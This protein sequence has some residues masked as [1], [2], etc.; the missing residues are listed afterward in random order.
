MNGSTWNINS[1][2]YVGYSGVGTLNLTNGGSVLAAGNTYVGINKG[3]AGVINFGTNGGILSTQ[4]LFAAPSQLTGIGTIYTGGL[5]SDVNLVFDQNYDP[6]APVP[7][8]GSIA[9]YLSGG[10]DLGAGWNGTGYLTI[11]DGLY[12]SSANGFLGYHSGST[13]VAT[14]SAMGFDIRST[15]DNRGDLYVGYSGSGTLNIYSGSGTQ[16]IGAA[17]SVFVGGNGYIGYN[18]GSTGVVTVGGT[19]SNW[20]IYGDLYV[21]NSGSG[22]LNIDGGSVWVAGDTYVGINTSS[23]DMISLNGGTFS[24][25]TIFA[26]QSQLTGTG[27]INA[28]GLV[29]DDIGLIFDSTHGLTQTFTLNG[30]SITLNLD[31]SNPGIWGNGSIGTPSLLIRD[32]MAVP[33]GPGY[34]G[35]YSGS[36]CEATVTG[37][38]SNWGTNGSLYIGYAANGT[39]NAVN[40]GSVGSCELYVGYSASGTLNITN[41]SSVFDCFFHSSRSSAGYIGYNSGSSGTA[42]VSGAGS[43]WTNSGALYV[44]YAGSGTLLDHQRRQRHQLL[45]QLY[46]YSDGYIGYYPSSTG[47]VTVDGSGSTWTNTAAVLLRRLLRQRD[48]EHHQRR[49]RHDRHFYRTAT[50]ATIPARRAR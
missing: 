47:T 8:F 21:G 12:V 6:N 20:I 5:V 9:V 1:D 22:R 26:T 25:R 28:R 49:K 18:S 17:A 34:I 31:L 27:T 37:S 50:S 23:T 41:G 2:L 24:T 15:W 42:T 32:G 39:L 48:A 29:N 33:S 4:S 45:Q 43:T 7:G 16:N 36:P 46:C 38:N 3:S 11:Q 35:Y 44:G 10:G 19:A 14:V 40:G 30:G 13:G